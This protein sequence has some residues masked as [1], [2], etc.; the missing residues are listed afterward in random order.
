MRCPRSTILTTVFAVVAFA[1]PTAAWGGGRSASVAVGS[2]AALLRSTSLQGSLAYSRCMRSH[3]V[4]DYP[5]PNSS[6]GT[7]K[8]QVIAARSK[9][10]SSRFNA[11]ERACQHLLPPSSSGPT[12]AEVAQIMNGMFKFAR[13]MRRHGVSNWPDPYLDVGRPTFDIHSI[14]YKAPRISS[15]I[16]ECQYLMPGSTLPRICSSLAAPA[17]SPPGS[18]GC[19]EEGPRLP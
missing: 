19:F 16:H 18:E 6:G 7:N 1:L 9:V 10:G 4:L 17:G 14:D 8:S 15:A 11:A 5:D 12:P 13:C 2:S 3:G